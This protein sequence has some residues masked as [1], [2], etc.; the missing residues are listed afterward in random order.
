MEQFSSKLLKI[1][2]KVPAGIMIIPLALGALINTFCPQILQIGTYTTATFTSAGTISITGVFFVCIGAQLSVREIPKVIRRGGTLLLAKFAIGALLGIVVGKVFGDAGFL[3]L[4]SLAI[5]SAVTNCNGGIYVS[6]MNIY[7]DETDVA[8]VS[9]LSINDGPF[10]TLI[11]MGASGLANIDM[12]SL[13]S[14][15]L[16]IIIGM[17]L[18][19]FSEKIKNFLDDGTKL[20]IPF[21]GFCLGGGI[22]LSNIIKSG[23]SGILLGLISA[24]VG[25][26][27][28]LLFDKLIAGRPGYAAWAVSTTAGNAVLV[29][30]SVALIDPSL[31]Q[32]AATATPQVAA[33]VVVT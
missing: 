1:L 30:A 27:F 31:T 11:A 4:S 5:I 29:P 21:I 10:L 25:G 8:S 23:I 12:M 17:L 18:G 26:V 16:P 33:A 9:L 6:L 15:V 19:N 7:G 13:L 2:G 24:F 14:T 3:G 32:A 20:L 28:I 22:N